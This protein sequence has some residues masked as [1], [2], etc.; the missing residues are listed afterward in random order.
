MTR[1]DCITGVFAWSTHGRGVF[2]G[3]RGGRPCY[4]ARAPLL[5][6]YRSSRNT[7]R[8]TSLAPRAAAAALS[9]HH[10]DE[11]RTELEHLAQVPGDG[12]ADPAL[13][14]RHAGIGSRGVDEGH[15]RNAEAVRELKEPKR[16][17]VA[18]GV[19]VAE[20]AVDVFL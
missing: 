15:H 7:P 4:P 20:V 9:R 8:A 12:F 19:R 3:P 11:R 14:G 6:C 5:P 2:D 17:A 10:R 1:T 18:L 13:L 16:F